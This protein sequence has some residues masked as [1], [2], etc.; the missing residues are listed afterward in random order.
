MEVHHY[1]QTERKKWHHYFWEFFML[2]LAVTL[3]FFV[4]NQREHLEDRKREKQYMQS[5]IADLERDTSEYAGTIAF[6]TKRMAGLDSMLDKL[7]DTPLNI[8]VLYYFMRKFG[9]QTWRVEPSQRTISQLKNAGG[10]RLTS[11]RFED[12]VKILQSGL[13]L[14][15]PTNDAKMIKRLSNRIYSLYGVIWTENRF[16][17]IAKAKAKTLILYI[18]KKYSFE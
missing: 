7:N 14:Q 3:G 2:F 10:M 13:H 4:E 8:P 6:N 17:N 5:M 9:G 15:L 11:L 16:L 1:T 12:P 18:R